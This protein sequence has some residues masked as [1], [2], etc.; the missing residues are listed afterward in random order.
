M[1]LM[2]VRVGRY[3]FRTLRD[4]EMNLQTKTKKANKN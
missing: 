3:G 4:K 1:N 2:N